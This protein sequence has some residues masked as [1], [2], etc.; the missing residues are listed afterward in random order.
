M[1]FKPSKEQEDIFNSVKYGIG[2]IVIN[3]KA[4]SGKSTTIIKALEQISEDKK[5]ILIAHNKDIVNHLKSKIKRDKKNT[6]ITTYHSL[7]YKILHENIKSGL[8]FN[9]Y[10]YVSYIHKNLSVLSGG[11]TLSMT[12]NK[13]KK[14][15]K[16]VLLLADYARFNLC[17]RE[18]E[19]AKIA[20]KYK[21]PIFSN[22]ISATKMVLDWGKNNL[23]EFDF[24]DMIWLPFELQLNT[25]FN[26]CD[27]VIVDEAQDTSPAQQELFKKCFKR[28]GRFIIVGDDR[29]CINVWCGSDEDAFKKF[30]KMDNTKQLPLNT[31]YRCPKSIIEKAQTIVSDIVCKDDAEDGEIN[32]ETNI[33]EANDGDMVLC[34]NTAPLARL[35]AEYLKKEKN[36][37]I[38]GKDI[39]KNLIDLINDTESD[40][41][42][43][44]LEK[45]GIIP[46]LY[47]DLFSVWYETCERYGVDKEGGLNTHEVMDIYDSIKA[48]ESLSYNLA[49]RQE[50]VDRIEKVFNDENKDGVCLSTVHKAKGLEADNVYL[51][52]PSLIPS[53][54]C[55][56]DWERKSEQ[57]LLYVAITRAKKTLNYVSEKLFPPG[58]G[59]FGTSLLLVELNNVLEKI[60]KCT[61]QK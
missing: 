13:V 55:K 58:N 12:N 47:M 30:S 52:C 44:T 61:I 48:I 41:I 38:R 16:N 59:F 42:S 31:S 17:Q 34:R 5:V 22:E 28:N 8:T 32:Y 25:F 14:Y 37:Y 3:A 11:E 21:V 27:W 1:Q 49:T 46:R 4:G 24:T 45:D 35:Y 20:E 57:N 43:L 2:N 6:I 18:K 40:E 26:K 54:L 19:I 56:K 15:R 10:K 29:Q 7:G 36:A 51:L 9:E 53:K 50:L 60:E 23:N 33:M 39:G